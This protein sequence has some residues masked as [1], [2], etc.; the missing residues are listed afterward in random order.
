[1]LVLSREDETILIGDDIE[2]RILRIAGRSVKI[3]LQAPDDVKIVR[4]ELLT[5]ASERVRP[6]AGL[7]S[8]G[9]A[10]GTVVR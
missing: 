2:I 4:G 7:V 5:E 6:L 8:P 1:M 9:R 3:G 10:T